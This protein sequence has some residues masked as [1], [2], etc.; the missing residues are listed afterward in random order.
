MTI[1]TI[2]GSDYYG[3][4]QACYSK[5]KGINWSKPE[6]IPSLGWQDSK[7]AGIVEG[8]CDVVPDYH[9]KTKKTLAIGHNVYYKGDRFYDTSGYFFKDD[10]S[11]LQRFAVYS[12]LDSNGGWSPRQ[13]IY[14]E[15]FK[16]CLSFVCGCTQ[17][18]FLPNGQIIIPFCIQYEN[19]LDVSV[20]SILCDF[21]GHVI[22]ALQRGNILEN[23]VERGL[24]E[25]SICQFKNLHYMTLRAE[26]DCG[27]VTVSDDGLNWDKI[28]PWQWDNGEKLTMSTTQ[29]HWLTLGG[30]LYLVYTRK[31]KQNDKVVRWRS[32]MFIAEVDTDKL[33]LK[34]ETEQ[35]VFPM[36]GDPDNPD[37]VALMGNFMPLALSPNEAIITDG[38]VLPFIDYSGKV[39]MARLFAD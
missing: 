23:P 7:Q 10:K 21:D 17:K 20:C 33:C 9:A 11:S 6:A 31:T 37:T 34:S 35:T 8:V 18:T 13:R 19:R 28:K 16:N 32:P 14:F 24:L 22:T 38:D 39:L 27:Y 3:P 2:G 1:Q 4:V 26:D 29:Q 5:D 15:E 36:R 12:V 30:K 25:P